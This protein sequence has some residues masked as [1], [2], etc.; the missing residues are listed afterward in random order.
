VTANCV[1]VNKYD[2]TS[3]SVGVVIAL[4]GRSLNGTVGASRTLADFLDGG[5]TGA[6]LTF[7][8]NRISKTFNDRFVT[9]STK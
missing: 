9:V 1:T 3:S 7:P 8:Q 4:A 5:E 6:S 2:G